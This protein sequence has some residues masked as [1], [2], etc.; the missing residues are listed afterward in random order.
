[1]A[2]AVSASSAF[3]M[4][5]DF[6]K[7]KKQSETFGRRP[8]IF[9]NATDTKVVHISTFDAIIHS[10]KN[11]ENGWNGDKAKAIPTSVIENALMMLPDVP[12]DGLKIFPTGRESIQFEYDNGDKSLEIGIYEDWFEIALFDDI[13]LIGGGTHE[14]TELEEIKKQLSKL[15]ES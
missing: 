4:Y 5:N 9:K 12:K 10:F 1:M 7:Q 2:Y 8:I 11:L 13:E 3:H 14:F 6:F 15:N